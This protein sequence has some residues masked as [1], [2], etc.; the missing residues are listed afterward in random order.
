MGSNALPDIKGFAYKTMH[1][2]ENIPRIEDKPI[3]GLKS[4]KNF[5]CSNVVENVTS[6]PRKLNETS[7]Y[8]AKKDY[9]A[10]PKYLSSRRNRIEDEYEYLRSMQLAENEN[11]MQAKHLMTQEE[12]NELRAAL[13]A[14]WTHVNHDYQSLTHMKVDSI[15]LKRKKENCE[16]ELIR[17]EK[18]LE[19][20]TKQYVFVDYE[21]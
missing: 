5:V 15:G 17:I 14:K 4:D 12:A 18:Y 10:V 2:K 21:A 7:N 16:K 20:L 19:K 3:M 9:G 1:R 6:A 8:L 13:K 11:K